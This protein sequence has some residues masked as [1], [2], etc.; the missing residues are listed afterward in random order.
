MMWRRV[1]LEPVPDWQ[2]VALVVIPTALI[3]L[4][5]ARAARSAVAAIM[6]RLL[7]DT[8]ATSSPLIKAPLRLIGLATFSLMFSVLI[9][10]A[11]EAAGLHPKAGLH[12]RTLSTWAFDSGLRVLLVAAFAFALIRTVGI[13]VKRFEHDVNFGTGLDALERAKRAR[14]LSNVLTN[15]TT[16]VILLIAA[17]MILREFDVDISPA[18]TGAGIIGVALGFGAQ[19][20]VRDLIGG[21]FLILENQIRVGDVAAINGIGGLVEA[22]NLRTTILRDEEGTVHVIPNGAITTLAN[23]SLNFSFY[24]INLPLAYSEDTD[25]ASQILHDEAE[26]LRKEDAFA[27]FILSALEIIGVDAFE[28]NAVRLKVRIKTAPLKQWF[29]GR[30]LRRRILKALKA[31]GIEMWSPQRTVTLREETRSSGEHQ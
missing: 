23:R 9:F 27:P 12:L 17:L 20:L 29:V 30:E 15:I 5:A 22:I 25:E 31:R 6:R 3:A 10:S 13:G 24:V 21:F 14:T 1:F 18:L 11:F 2:L 16:I 28:E 8:I 7:R 19:T 26:V 4:L